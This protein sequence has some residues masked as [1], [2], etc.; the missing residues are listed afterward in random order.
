MSLAD[1][2]NLNFY[3]RSYCRHVTTTTIFATHR[4]ALYSRLSGWL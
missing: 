4:L 3:P 2:R 1:E